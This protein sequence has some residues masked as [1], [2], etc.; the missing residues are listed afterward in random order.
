MQFRSKKG[1]RGRRVAYPIMSKASVQPQPSTHA[2]AEKDTSG[3]PVIGLHKARTIHGQ[4]SP[5]AQTIDEVLEAR[6]TRDVEKWAKA[7]NR[8]D[9]RGVDSFPV[10]T[11]P[12]DFINNG[13]VFAYAMEQYHDKDLSGISFLGYADE[14]H[15]AEVHGGQE[16][17]VQGVF[18]FAKQHDGKAEVHL[19]PRCVSTIAKGKIEN[20]DDFFGFVAVAHEIGHIVG[21][22]PV[23]MGEGMAFDEGAN[24]LLAAR[25]VLNNII[26]PRGLRVKMREH[27]LT[28]YKDEVGLVADT[29]LLL[30]QGHPEKALQWL[31]KFRDAPTELTEEREKKLVEIREKQRHIRR[32]RDTAMSKAI[33]EPT[34]IDP[35][36][37]KEM[38]QMERPHPD[39]LA[40][41]YLRELSIEEG[42][43]VS[44]QEAMFKEARRKLRKFHIHED[45][46]PFIPLT[47]RYVLSGEDQAKKI[48]WSSIAV[49]SALQMQYPEAYG[50]ISRSSWWWTYY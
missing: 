39:D 8:W 13:K 27:P 41:K 12:N 49:R 31:D 36:L 50:M 47:H 16:E 4:R 1:K 22:T 21:K 5:R 7:P 34:G 26:I 3:L 15:F 29:A 28:A 2:F 35:Q 23:K 46:D 17:E 33:G 30:N 25:F 20:E 11:M 44:P 38:L 18:A 40:M 48:Y 24:E 9:I 14:K 19:S 43:V 6:I 45:H 32:W 37:D 10:P 42:K